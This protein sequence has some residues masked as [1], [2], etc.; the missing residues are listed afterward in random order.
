MQYITSEL[1]PEKNNVKVKKKNSAID[2]YRASE[3][4]KEKSVK[5]KYILHLSANFIE[6]VELEG[7]NQEK[8]EVSYSLFYSHDPIYQ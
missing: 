5:S 2:Q 3:R 4:Q 7:K 6:R 8:S 1:K